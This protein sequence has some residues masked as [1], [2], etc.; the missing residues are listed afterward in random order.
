MRKLVFTLFAVLL[1]TLSSCS[2]DDSPESSN[3]PV[4]SADVLLT[5]ITETYDDG[6]SASI[7][8]SYEGNKIISAFSE[9]YEETYT[10]TGDLLTQINEYEEGALISQTV[11][12]YDSQDR[13]RT[14]VYTS[15][16]INQTNE[17]TYNE[18]GTITM[19]ENDVNT[20][21]LTFNNGNL[22]SE[23]HVDGNQDY[24]FTYDDKKSP[25]Y[26]IFQRSVFSL[27][28]SFEAYKN[29][30]LSYVNTGG[31]TL[32]DGFTNTFTY[33]ANGFP[34]TGV[35]IYEPGTVNEETIL[36]Q[37]FYE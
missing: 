25:F 23:D 19:N 22:M 10:Y 8:F 24:T 36:L 18:D 17:Y 16:N 26:N 31:A 30:V 35:T 11:L 28:G 2:S 21:I 6:T 29:N 13:L 4:S 20:Y 14:E 34:E 33:N 7:N 1:I 32:S 37:F 27:V 12:E 3:P 15:G 5:K 9:G